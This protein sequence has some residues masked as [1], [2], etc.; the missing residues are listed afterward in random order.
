M[1]VVSAIACYIIDP[2]IAFFA[3]ANALQ[4]FANTLHFQITTHCLNALNQ[5][6]SRCRKMRINEH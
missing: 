1:L 3:L 2:A 5:T 6:S 4:K